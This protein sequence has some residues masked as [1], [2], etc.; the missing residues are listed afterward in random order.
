MSISSVV[1]ETAKVSILSIT[2]FVNVSFEFSPGLSQ[3]RLKRFLYWFT[4]KDHLI[5]S[6]S[7]MVNLFF[8]GRVFR[9][10]EQSP[11]RSSQK[12]EW[13][14]STWGGSGGEC[15][16]SGLWLLS[17]NVFQHGWYK[18]EGGY[19]DCKECYIVLLAW[20]P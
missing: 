19:Y 13:G 12:S 20:W 1:V 4:F 17:I 10:L 6:F 3:E 16:S 15:G 14:S 18:E 9:V 2:S 11:H 8:Q 5:Q 7:K